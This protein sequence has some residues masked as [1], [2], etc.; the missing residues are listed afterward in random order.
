MKERL[1]FYCAALVALVLILAA[2]PSHATER[3]D[4]LIMPDA[5]QTQ[6]AKSSGTAH[7]AATSK[8]Q[9]RASHT[10]SSQ[11]NVNP[12]PQ[13]KGKSAVKKNSSASAK[14]DDGAQSGT[15]AAK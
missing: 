4:P 12:L 8:K 11:A 13:A 2:V 1:I 10:K 9:A 3:R 7:R 15:S 14:S 6:D 5:Q